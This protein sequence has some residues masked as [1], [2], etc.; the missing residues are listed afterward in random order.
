MSKNLEGV[1]IQ[2]G[3]AL[4][5]LKL[6][7]ARIKVA[8]INGDQHARFNYSEADN[9]AGYQYLELFK[10]VGSSKEETAAARDW[11]EMYSDQFLAEGGKNAKE[12][13]V[14]I[15]KQWKEAL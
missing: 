11:M 7:K 3:S 4:V 8:K 13:S 1:L 5:W 10:V 9:E 2:F 6:A 14:W 12:F 15:K